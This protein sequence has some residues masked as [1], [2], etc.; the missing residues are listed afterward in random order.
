[1]SAEYNECTPDDFVVHPGS[2]EGS[3]TCNVT[4]KFPE[5]SKFDFVA[6][7]S[8]VSTFDHLYAQEAWFKVSTLNDPTADSTNLIWGNSYLSGIVS[9]PLIIMCQLTILSGPPR[10]RSHSPRRNDS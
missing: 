1:M 3:P 4:I 9:D 8:I 7:I 10:T 5:G 2:L 6:N